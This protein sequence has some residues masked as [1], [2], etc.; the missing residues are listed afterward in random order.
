MGSVRE[1][2]I[3]QV[4][5]IPGISGVHVMAHR[6]E[7]TVGEIL[8]E[9]NLLPRPWQRHPKEVAPASVESVTT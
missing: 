6:Q 3:Q 7:E 8:E 5:E 1:E 4:K 9:A 2:I